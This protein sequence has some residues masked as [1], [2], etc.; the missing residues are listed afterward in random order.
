MGQ[1]AAAG[2]AKPNA[3]AFLKKLPQTVIKNGS[4]V[5]VRGEIGQMIGGGGGGA[6]SG[7]GG[8]PGGVV[9]IETAAGRWAADAAATP[10]AVGGDILASPVKAGGGT[11]RPRLR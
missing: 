6:L 9:A 7:G 11:C 4:V 5:Q 10:A 1:M 8:E 2:H 3:E